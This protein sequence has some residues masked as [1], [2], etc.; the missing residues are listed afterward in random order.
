MP[1]AHHQFNQCE[2]QVFQWWVKEV[3]D[4]AEEKAFIVPMETRFHKTGST[5]EVSPEV[6]ARPVEGK[7]ELV[8]A[9]EGC[10]EVKES[11]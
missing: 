5:R 10:E 11:G 9:E 6:E 2:K 7:P 1:F 4:G 3:V 8:Q